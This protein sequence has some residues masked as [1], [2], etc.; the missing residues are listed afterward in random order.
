MTGDELL[1]SLSRL[2]G[3]KIQ[4]RIEFRGETT[5]SIQPEDLHEVAK[6]CR[7]EL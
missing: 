1:D 7:D 6:V 3:A 4:S 5:F 2:L